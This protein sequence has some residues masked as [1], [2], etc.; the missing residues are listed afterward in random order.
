MLTLNCRGRLLAASQPLVMGIINI[1]PDSFFSGSRMV[2]ADE[3]LRKAEQM[4]QDGADI[5]DMGAQ[6]SRPDSDLVSAEEE[7]S[8]LIDKIDAVHRRFPD[9]FISVD[10]FY[11]KV[12]T[13]AVAAGACIVNDI[14]AGNIDET[15]I[16]AVVALQ[17]P[18]VL[19]H[20]P[21]TPKTM[22]AHTGYEDV[23]KQV[24]DFL[25]EK[26]A[27]IEK[28]GIRDISIDP[29]FGFGKTV[30]QNFEM[31]RHLQAFKIMGAPVL[32]GLSRKST[33]TQTL[34]ISPAEALNGTTVLNTIALIHGAGILRV[35]D[36]KE[37]KE[38]VTLVQAASLAGKS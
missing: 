14:S 19:M 17:V 7:L 24:L 31:L 29:G 37:A 15:L 27:I 30:A 1:T 2:A 32:A 23:T 21:G 13:E 10:T 5:L 35:H 34:G 18:Y 16:P 12:A 9:A 22:Q 33:I 8:R 26:K 11:G 36:V 3:V 28:Q 6:S 38:A 4:I 20:M 25:I